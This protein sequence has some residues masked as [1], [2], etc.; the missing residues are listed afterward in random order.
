MYTTTTPARIDSSVRHL[1]ES[2]APG[3]QASYL[4]VRPEPG[5]AFD[6]C[7]SNVRAKSERDGGRMLCGW[8]LWEWPRVLV[9][10]EFHAVW[11]S[12]GGQM[13]EITPKRHGETSVLF[14]PDERCGYE[15]KVVDNVRVPLDDDQLIHHFIRVSRAIVEASADGTR[16]GDRPKR[17]ASLRRAQ[18]F[19]GHSIHAGL[20]E[21]DPCLCGSGSRYRRC[22]GCEL[23]RA[24]G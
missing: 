4:D 22:H 14:V 10:A 23:E 7:F 17:I 9:E 11:L 1:I 24:L 15:G 3:G 2:L 18:R 5:A 6:G 12:P 8:Q 21:H 13:E 19:V 16:A 20:R